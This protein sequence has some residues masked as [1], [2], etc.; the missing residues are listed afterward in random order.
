MRNRDKYR[1]PRHLYVTI[2]A[3]AFCVLA[4]IAYSLY[5]GNQYFDIVFTELLSQADH[6]ETE[7]QRLMVEDLRQFLISQII[8]ILV[9][10]TL[11]GLILLLLYRYNSQRVAVFNALQLS[12]DRLQAILDNTPTTICVKDIEGRYMLVNR[13]FESDFHINADDIKGKTDRELFEKNLAERLSEND[14]LVLETHHSIDLEEEIPLQD[15]PH[16]YAVVKFPLIERDGEIWA[17]GTISTDITER[18]RQEEARQ[19]LEMQLHQSQ[20]MEAVGQL[21]G[22]VAHDFNNILTIILGNTEIMKMTVEANP[23]SDKSIIQNLDTIKES[24]NRAATLV[25][26]LLVYSRQDVA[27]PEVIDLNT[28]IDQVELMLRRLLPEDI[29]LSIN[30]GRE[31]HQVVADG[32]QI[33][34][35]LMNLVINARDAMLDGGS[36]TIETGNV[37]LDQSYV[38]NHAEA[39]PGQHVMLAVS[40]SGSGMDAKVMSHIYEPFFTTKPVGEG[41]GLG[42]ATVYGIVN[43]WKGNITV[44][45]EPGQGSTFKVF[46]PAVEG[47]VAGVAS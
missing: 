38:S 20:K 46:L 4:I 10:I 25:R 45:S 9:G 14:R 3:V 17:V 28:V 43:R 11:A 7:L 6:A 2:C 27:Q 13:Q 36:L 5:M 35:I 23:T 22:G 47:S 32:R 30:A 40:D 18:K 33:E 12:E 21:A 44:D 16:T 41:T 24:A 34:Q 26:Q 39:C 31:L 1:L 15:G 19:S 37:Y 29:T 42:L 8:L